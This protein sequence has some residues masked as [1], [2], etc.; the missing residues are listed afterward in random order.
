MA[1]HGLTGGGGCNSL[2][3]TITLNKEKENHVCL[4]PEEGEG[5][6]GLPKVYVQ[7]YRMQ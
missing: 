6:R 5:L 2:R 7:M 3:S 1:V 4:L